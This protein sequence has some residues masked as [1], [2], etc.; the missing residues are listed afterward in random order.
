MKRSFL[1]CSAL[2]LAG[3]GGI[4]SVNDTIVTGRVI[5]PDGKPLGGGQIT[6]ISAADKTK[7]SGAAIMPDGTYTISAAPRG[8]C[9]ATVETESI[10]LA[11][12]YRAPQAPKGT[13]VIPPAGGMTTPQRYIKIDKRFAKPETSGL[14]ITVSSTKTEWDVQL[15]SI[16]GTSQP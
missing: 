6:L 12:V 15:K 16:G 7:G 11:A 9:L 13:P 5:G 14:K 8:D 2:A 1:I 4:S 3:C 10:R